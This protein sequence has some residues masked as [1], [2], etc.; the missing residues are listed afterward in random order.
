M[1]EIK[2]SGVL[3]LGSQGRLHREGEVSSLILDPVTHQ[4]S[5]TVARVLPTAM[6]TR[7]D[8]LSYA[9]TEEGNVLRQQQDS[10]LFE[11]TTRLLTPRSGVSSRRYKAYQMNDENLKFEALKGL[12]VEKMIATR[13]F[14]ESSRFAS[15]ADGG[16]KI[17]LLSGTN[18]VC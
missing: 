18:A 5:L 4:D 11:W 15:I 14:M 6:A 13:C 12:D 9:V 8:V 10:R 17:L 7:E 2:Y 3:P 16:Q 1:T